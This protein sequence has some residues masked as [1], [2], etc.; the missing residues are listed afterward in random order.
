[1]PMLSRPKA[2]W[3]MFWAKTNREA[4]DGL[5]VRPL[6]AHLL[7]V[8]HA[9]EVLWER[10]LPSAYRRQLVDAL[11][12]SATESRRLLS[13]WI[14]LHDVGKAIPSFQTL[15]RQSRERLRSD[16]GLPIDD[17]YGPAHRI[18]HGHASIA[19][20]RIWLRVRAFPSTTR[21]LLEAMAAFVGF[22]HGRLCRQVEWE[23]AAD[24]GRLGDGWRTAQLELIDVIVGAWEMP[25]VSGMKAAEPYPAWLLPFA[26]WATLADWAGSMASHF[27]VVEHDETPQSYLSKSRG[28][29]EEAVGQEG[30]AYRA[31]LHAPGFLAIFGDPESGFTKAHPIQERLAEQIEIT[32]G[33]PTLTI[34][35][36]PTGEGKTEAALYLAARQQAQNDGQAGLYIAMPS[37]ATSN[38]A[39]RRVRDEFLL[40]KHG[41]CQERVNQGAHISATN[42][43]AHL[44]L[45]HGNDL[46][47]PLFE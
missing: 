17:A 8:A 36:A 30:L 27:G 18:H 41:P 42:Q 43:F 39:F 24:D 1:M 7:D 14:G 34:V 3:H 28:Y 10:R 32:G 47:H 46:L 19:L 21:T 2:A 23:D 45:V 9:A 31:G 12:L 16:A 22:H 20:L 5:P 4:D 44:R 15:H 25:D 38:E 11:G 35:E 37:Q 13:L 33:G 40:P 26:G 6:W 29:A